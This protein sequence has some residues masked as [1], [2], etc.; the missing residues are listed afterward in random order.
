MS[1]LLATNGRARY[2]S[3]TDEEALEAYKLVTKYENLNPSLEP[4]HAFAE[5][6]KIAPSLDKGTIIV[7]DSCGDAAKDMKII[8]ERLGRSL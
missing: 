8:K 5:A 2:S 3:A 1:G 6:I 4:S 7:I